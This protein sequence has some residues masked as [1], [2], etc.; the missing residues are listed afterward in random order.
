MFHEMVVR[1]AK[2]E[3]FDGI[4]SSVAVHPTDTHPSTEIRLSALGHSMDDFLID[5]L[6]PASVFMETSVSLVRHLEEIEVD[7]TLMEHQA[8]VSTGVGKQPQQE[9]AQS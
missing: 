8:L 6:R 7:L 4:G 5:D 1:N 2:P 9:E 3:I